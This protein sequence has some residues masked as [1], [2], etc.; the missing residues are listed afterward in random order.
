M[1][2]SYEFALVQFTRFRLVRWRAGG[3][4][5]ARL[6]RKAR[7]HL[8]AAISLLQAL[9]PPDSCVL[10]QL[11]LNRWHSK[12]NQRFANFAV[13]WLWECKPFHCTAARRGKG[14]SGA[15]QPT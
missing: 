2:T 13:G 5:F 8:F 3:V 12:N 6:R 11:R 1:L 7:H 14:I 15:P 10:H 4:R 9:L